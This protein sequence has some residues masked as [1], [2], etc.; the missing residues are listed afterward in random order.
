MREI[1]Y[2]TKLIYFHIF[3]SAKSQ[4]ITQC[5]QKVFWIETIVSIN[6]RRQPRKKRQIPSNMIGYRTPLKYIPTIY[7]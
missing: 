2:I 6:T 5:E 3:S 4:T 1:Y 7:Y